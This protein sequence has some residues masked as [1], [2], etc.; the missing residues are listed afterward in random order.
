MKTLLISIFISLQLFAFSQ[1]TLD[2]TYEGSAGFSQIKEGEFRF[3]NYDTTSNQCIIYD[4]QHQ[5]LNAISL[6]LTDAQYLSSINYVSESLFNLD[7]NIELLFTYSEWIEI[8][9]IWY[10]TYTS[11]IINDGG[12]LL[13]EIPGGQYN[14]ITATNSGSEL[15]SWI[16]DF[17]LS[18]YPIETL[19]YHLPGTYSD[20][21]TKDADEQIAAWPN[22]CSQQIYLPISKNSHSIKIYNEQGML[23]DEVNSSTTESSVKY[24]VNH[25][26]PG[27]YFYQSVSNNIDGK[28]NKFIIQ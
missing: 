24:S 22:P 5:Q 13:L 19:V 10:L 12:G 20:I 28:I 21:E 23:V 14:S 3:Y 25:L 6:G 17:A 27:L 8:D 9:T 2:A 4:E 26:S 11:K 1:I 15:L 18:S 7:E 16:Y